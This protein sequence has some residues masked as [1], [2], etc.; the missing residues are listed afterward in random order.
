[1]SI[2]RVLAGFGLALVA[3]ASSVAGQNAAPHVAE[4]AVLTSLPVER[5]RLPLGDGRMMDVA[6]YVPHSYDPSAAYPVL[7]IPDA[8]PL[9]GLLQ[10]VSFLWA[11]EGTAQGAILVGLP[12]G[13]NAGAIWTNRSYYLL[14]DSVGV[15][16]YYG[17]QLPLNTGGGAAELAQFLED[18]VLPAVQERYSVDP[19]RLGLAGFSMG[20]LFAAWH[21]VT[22][23]GLFS[24]YLIIAPPLSPPMI[25]EDF[26]RALEQVVSNGFDRPTRVYVSYAENDLEMVKAG[27]SSFVKVWE[28][29]D[30]PLLTFRSELFPGL[31]HDGGA[32]PALTNGYMFLY[33]R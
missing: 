29:A 12:F 5:L 31:R 20:G 4:E 30:D 11:E 13:S 18:E 7:L 9:M 25:D 3:G 23:P 8:D 15:V 24:D 28:A 26:T 33:G 27:A 2:H 16:D 14:P 32:V 22:H 6:V 19:G 17:S 21:L 10:S 1:M